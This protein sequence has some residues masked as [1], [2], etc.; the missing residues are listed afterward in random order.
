MTSHEVQIRIPLLP[1]SD[2]SFIDPLLDALVEGLNDEAGEFTD[3]AEE[4]GDEIAYYLY[5]PDSARLIELARLKLRDFPQL[6]NVYATTQNGER[7][8]LN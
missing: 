2:T 7:V 8:D 3:D 5:G 6:V 1:D 4:D